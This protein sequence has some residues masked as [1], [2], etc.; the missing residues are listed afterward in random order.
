MLSYILMRI[1]RMIPQ[2]L[3]ISIL[4][5]IIIQ[6]PPGDYLEQHLNRLRESGR[7]I[8][9]AEIRRWEEMY[10]LDKPM[11]VQYAKWIWNIVTKF[12]F[13]YTFQWN[14]PVKEVIMSR[15][16]LTFLIALGSALFTWVVAIPIGIFVAVKQYSAFDYFFTFLGFIG[17]A[18]PGFLLAMV[19]MYVAYTKFGIK[20]GGLFSPRVSA[21]RLELGQGGGHAQAHVAAGDL[22]G[23]RWDCQ[24]DPYA[25]RHDAG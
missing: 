1:V 17:L 18:V 6:L 15:M 4:A 23:H 11:Y 8:D 19:L 3:L 7:E 10:G 12:D 21:S 24:Y 25:A 14:K 2:I 13:G 5:F 9:E 22:V 20:V 16:W